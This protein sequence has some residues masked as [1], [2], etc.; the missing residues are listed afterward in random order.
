MGEPR[1]SADVGGKRVWERSAP[2]WATAR[3]VGVP[4]TEFRISRPPWAAQSHR[5]PP[6]GPEPPS[7]WS[8]S[9]LHWPPAP[10]IAV[11]LAAQEKADA[12]HSLEWFRPLFDVPAQRD[13]AGSRRCS[14]SASSRPV[15][16]RFGAARPGGHELQGALLEM[17]HLRG[18]PA[19]APRTRQHILSP[20]NV[21]SLVAL[22][23]TA[24]RTILRCASARRN[25]P[26]KGSGCSSARMS[27]TP[28]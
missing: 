22:A 11:A 23:D 21:P 5:E 26:N 25:W 14:T 8:S 12:A 13:P 15:R 4:G 24:A 9:R 3:L 2:P 6:G 16:S 28:K 18:Q 17:K 10:V 19:A 20:T 27:V 7:A 1:D